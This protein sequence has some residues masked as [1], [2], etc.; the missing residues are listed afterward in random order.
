MTGPKA[1]VHGRVIDGTGAEPVDDGVVLTRD[2]RTEAVAPASEVE[3]PDDAEV[4]DASGFTVMPGL[5]EGHAHVGGTTAAQQVLRLSAQ[6]GITTVCSV[7]ANEAGIALRDGIE[8]RQVRGCAR[9]VAG[10]VVSPTFGHVRYRTADGPWEVRKAVREMVAAG[11]DFIKTAAS[12]GFWGE[13]EVCSVRNYT[14]EELE[15]LVDEAHA[16]HRPVVVHAHTQ[17]GLN[18]AIEA[19]VDQIHHGAFIDEEGVR[20]ILEADL[21]YMP[22]LRVTCDRNIAAWPDRP[23]MEEEMTQAQP[24]HREGVRLAHELGVKIALGS[25]YPSSKHVWDIGDA[26]LWELQELV[27]A[28]LTEIEAIVASVKTT[29]EAYR[30]E[31][32]GPLVPGNRAD[33]IIVDGDPLADIGV[34]YDQANVKLTI[35]DGVVESADEDYAGQYAIRERQPEDRPQY[36]PL[37][38]AD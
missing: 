30:L 20:G 18:N 36:D 29:P 22:T 13:D 10:C 3:V 34:L 26:C 11:A 35:K 37:E 17:P 27:A 14:L 19:G 24:V 15:A 25:D 1:I 21:C 32:I 5:V 6:R 16:W 38:G 7:S 2:G 9:L 23:W 8:A 33:L 28:G 4:I 31:D 12:G